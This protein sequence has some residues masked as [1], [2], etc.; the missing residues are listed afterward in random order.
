MVV[1]LGLGSSNGDGKPQVKQPG[2]CLLGCTT[3][4]L[5]ADFLEV[6]VVFPVRR[7]AASVRPDRRA[8]RRSGARTDRIDAGLISKAAGSPPAPSPSLRVPT[9]FHTR[10][11]TTGSR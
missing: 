8:S 1:D 11:P 6:P 10:L 5:S 4:R 7:V 2:V 9:P 3:V